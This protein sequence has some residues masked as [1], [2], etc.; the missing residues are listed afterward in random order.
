[1]AKLEVQPRQ[2]KATR[3]FYVS[4]QSMEFLRQLAVQHDATVSAVL[5]AILEQAQDQEEEVA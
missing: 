2:V 4:N 3:S 5:E 1:M